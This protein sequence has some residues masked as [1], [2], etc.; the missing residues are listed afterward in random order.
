MKP[1]WVFLVLS[2]SYSFAYVLGLLF[3]HNIFLPLLMKAQLIKILVNRDLGS[4]SVLCWSFQ[5]ILHVTTI[6]ED[7]TSFMIT[8]CF[9]HTHKSHYTVLKVTFFFPLFSA[10]YLTLMYH[11]HKNKIKIVSL[12]IDFHCRILVLWVWR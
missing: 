10:M 4:Q 3:R 2:F 12:P 5:N 1:F 9:V 6:L 8:L 7:F 11:K